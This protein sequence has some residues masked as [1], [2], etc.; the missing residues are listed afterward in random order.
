MHSRGHITKAVWMIC[1]STQKKNSMALQNAET[2]SVRGC[3]EKSKGDAREGYQACSPPLKGRGRAGFLQRVA[4]EE[5]RGD[6]AQALN[7]LLSR[8]IIM[9]KQSVL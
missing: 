4:A 7:S 3:G 5:S 8:R 6:G 9:K 1:V 2:C